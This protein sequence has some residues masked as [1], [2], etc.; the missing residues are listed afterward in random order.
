M[1]FLF[2]RL[3]GGSELPLEAA[4][5]LQVAR[6]VQIHAWEMPPGLAEGLALGVPSAVDL[7]SPQDLVDF[8]KTLESVLRANEPRLK[9][10][11]IRIEHGQPHRPPVLVLEALLDEESGPKPFHFKLPEELSSHAVR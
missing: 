1:R 7:G 6:L 9:N 4:V 5:A 10:P 2:E 11:R 8:A 3:D